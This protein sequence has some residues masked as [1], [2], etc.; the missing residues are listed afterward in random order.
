MKLFWTF[1]H[2]IVSHHL[3]F[4]KQLPKT[5]NKVLDFIEIKYAIKLI[6]R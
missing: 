3:L 5:I 4:L 6:H 2:P 1:L